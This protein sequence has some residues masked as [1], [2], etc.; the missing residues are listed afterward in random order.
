VNRARELLSFAGVGVVG[1]VVDAGL[2]NLISH[3]FL[4]P[5]TLARVPSFCVAV[6]ATWLL[7]SLL[8]FRGAYLG[9]RSLQKYFGTNS[10]GFVT[11]WL[12]F[13]LATHFFE[14]A[15]AFP[16]VTLGIAAIF[17]LLV[18]FILARRFVF[19]R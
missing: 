10:I 16:T 8:T 1:F 7:N 5:D 15:H 4:I 11:N 14:V 18:N 17:S 12:V 6:V 19:K 9:F 13:L 3:L 2:M